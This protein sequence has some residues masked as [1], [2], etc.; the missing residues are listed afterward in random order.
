MYS[1]DEDSLIVFLLVFLQMRLSMLFCWSSYNCFHRVYINSFAYLTKSRDNILC[2]NIDMITTRDN[3]NSCIHLTKTHWLCFADVPTLL[4][5]CRYSSLLFVN[6]ILLKFLQLFSSCLHQQFCLLD[7][8]SL[9]YFADVP[10]LLF[11]CRYSLIAIISFA[12][13]TKSRDNILCDNNT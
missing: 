5:V 9:L 1:L 3:I 4:F 6:V 2:D 7:E 10:T 12:Y 8:D 11:V 13:L